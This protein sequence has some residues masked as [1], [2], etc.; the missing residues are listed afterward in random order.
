MF[1]KCR[2]LR[3]PESMVTEYSYSFICA[4]SGGYSTSLPQLLDSKE[5]FFSHR[6]GGPFEVFRLWVQKNTLRPLSPFHRRPISSRLSTNLGFSAFFASC[7]F[8]ANCSWSPGRSCG[9]AGVTGAP[10]SPNSVPFAMPGAPVV[11][12]CSIYF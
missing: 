11:A 7:C 5:S 8:C 10:W 9:A 6:L 4:D 12:S 1:L 3:Y 2:I